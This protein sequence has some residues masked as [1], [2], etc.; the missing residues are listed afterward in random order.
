MEK[1]VVTGFNAAYW[2]LC[3]PCWLGS[4]RSLAAYQDGIIVLDTGD[5][6]D[7]H[8]AR[9]T[10][11]DVE[12]VPVQPAFHHQFNQ[13]Q[14]IVEISRERPGFYAYWS[15]DCYFQ[16]AID[17][18]FSLDGLS[19][20]AGSVPVNTDGPRAK[21]YRNILTNIFEKYGS[22]VDCSFVAGDNTAWNGF[23][24]FCDYAFTNG[25]VTATDTTDSLLMNC[26]VSFFPGHAF[27][28]PQTWNSKASSLRR[29][30]GL[31][32]VGG[33]VSKVIQPGI[34]VASYFDPQPYSFQ[35][36][37]KNLYRDWHGALA[38][39]HVPKSNGRRMIFRNHERKGKSGEKS[40]ADMGE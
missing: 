28:R 39:G 9:L 22:L 3:A 15:P 30:D 4:L 7:T 2:D 20:C 18:V 8:K 32:T 11:Q 5:L 40:R 38:K 27:V 34:E 10:K 35:E 14:T 23:M 33:V 29:I 21:N 37:H 17:D 1:Y 36:N 31:F 13:F 24:T 6:S 12:I 26:Y 16:T 25:L 19:V